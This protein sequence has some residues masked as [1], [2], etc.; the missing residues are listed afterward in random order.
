MFETLRT[1]ESKALEDENIENEDIENEDIES[2]DIENW[3]IENW[4]MNESDDV[5]LINQHEWDW[6]YLSMRLNLDDQASQIW[7][8]SNNK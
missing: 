6:N 5:N 7:S 3:D 4:D 1:R 8:F 2:E